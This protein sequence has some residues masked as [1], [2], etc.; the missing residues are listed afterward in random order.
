MKDKLSWMWQ[1]FKVTGDMC[2]T[3]SISKQIF[4]CFEDGQDDLKQG[5][6]KFIVRTP[7]DK[8]KNPK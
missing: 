5:A 2:C 1:V 6:K 8:Q 4:S 7:N 3:C